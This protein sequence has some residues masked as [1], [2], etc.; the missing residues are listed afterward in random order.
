MA[1]KITIKYHHTPILDW[2]K[3]RKT[4]QIQ[5]RTSKDT[6][7]LFTLAHLVVMQKWYSH[8]GNLFGNFP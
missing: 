7:E 5:I 6:K 3:F 8:S 4:L 1:N 2:L